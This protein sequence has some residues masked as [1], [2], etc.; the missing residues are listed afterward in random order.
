MAK[1]IAM[2]ANK[3]VDKSLLVCGFL[4]NSL[5]WF[6]HDTSYTYSRLAQEGRRVEYTALHQDKK[7][8]IG[9]MVESEEDMIFVDSSIV[10]I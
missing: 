4:C 5:T 2:G 1:K 3:F 6:I 8:Y 9:V 10:M 7:V